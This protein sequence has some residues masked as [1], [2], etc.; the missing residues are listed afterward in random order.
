MVPP[1]AVD[2]IAG[3][4]PESWEPFDLEEREA[5]AIEDDLLARC[6]DLRGPLIVVNDLSFDLDQGPY[7]VD[8]T[9]LP[10]FVKTFDVRVRDYFMHASLFVV[11]P[12][13]GIVIIVQDD[14]YIAKVQGRSVMAVRCASEEE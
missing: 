7:F 11:S 6:A 12:V 3:I 10:E 1:P 2:R 8:A 5:D 4:P 13:T 14:G 9:R